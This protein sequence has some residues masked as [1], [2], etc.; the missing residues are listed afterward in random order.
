MPED[1]AASGEA[2][3]RDY[4]DIEV[5]GIRRKGP[6]ATKRSRPLYVP[7]MR[8]WSKAARHGDFDVMEDPA[9]GVWVGR[10]R[11]YAVVSQGCDEAE[12]LAATHEAFELT[13]KHSEA[14]G[15]SLP[16]WASEAPA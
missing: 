6:V 10:H 3:V 5:H 7:E 8:D 12:A 15:I 14:R 16:R 4:A 11:T 13:T 9:A 1:K 2:E